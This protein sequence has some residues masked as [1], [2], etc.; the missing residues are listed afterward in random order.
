[1]PA[2]DAAGSSSGRRAME[3]SD[4]KAMGGLAEDWRRWKRGERVLAIVLAVMVTLTL[5]AIAH[6]TI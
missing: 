3:F 4:K 6:F 1:L 5:A 2:G